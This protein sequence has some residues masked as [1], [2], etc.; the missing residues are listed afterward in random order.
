MTRPS[1]LGWLL[2]RKQ[3]SYGMIRVCNP[4]VNRCRVGVDLAGVEARQLGLKTSSSPES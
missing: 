3:S 2:I 1:F 4:K